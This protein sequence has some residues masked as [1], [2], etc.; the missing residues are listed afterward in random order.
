MTNI[1]ALIFLQEDCQDPQF[2]KKLI[3][4]FFLDNKHRLFLVMKPNVSTLFIH[5]YYVVCTYTFLCMYYAVI[6]QMV[7]V[8]LR[9]WALHLKD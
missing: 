3:R 5:I 4:H 6:T 8:A 2:L 9:P 1:L 7:A